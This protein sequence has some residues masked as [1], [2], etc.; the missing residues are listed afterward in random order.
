MLTF[1]SSF[2]NFQSP[3]N[4]FLSGQIAMVL[5]GVWMYNFIDKFA[6]SMEWGAAP[7][8]ASDPEKYPMVTLTECDILCIPKGAK[9]PDEAFEFIAYVNTQ[10]EM[11]KLN[12]GQRKFSPLATTSPDFIKAHPNP[13]I[14]LFLD[15]ARSPHAKYVPRIQVWDELDSEMGVASDQAY[16]GIKTP[17]EALNAVQG[18]MQWRLDRIMRRWDKVEAERLKEWSQ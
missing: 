7:F 16:R 12:L 6:P 8:P 15:M 13:Y 10:K 5:Q 4:P 11:E 3:Q 2:G 14:Q 9:H 18:R 1:G 17:E